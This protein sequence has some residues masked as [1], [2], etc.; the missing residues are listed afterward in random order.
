MPEAAFPRSHQPPLAQE[1]SP[2]RWLNFSA[3]GVLTL[4]PGKVEIGQGILTAYAQVAVDELGVSP[5]CLRLAPVRTGQSPNEGVTS[6]SQSVRESVQRLRAHCATIRER[7]RTEIARCLGVAAGDLQLDSGA[8]LA[9]DGRSLSYWD[10]P[11]EL[12]LEKPADDVAYPPATR[13]QALPRIDL[14]ARI[15]GERRYLHDLT[16]PGM[17][18]GRMLRDAAIGTHPDLPEPEAFRTAFP[19]VLLVQEGGMIG[20]VAPSEHRLDQACRALH[21]RLVWHGGTLLPDESRLADWL[22]SARAETSLV[23]ASGPGRCTRQIEQ[24]Y[25]RPFLAHA[26]IGPSCAIARWQDGHLHVLSHSQGP[27]NLR[28][29]LAL[30]FGLSPEAVLVEHSEGAGCYGHNGA[31]DV[32]LDAALLSRAVNGRPVRVQ[33]SRRDELAKAPFGAAMR[34]RMAAD[35]DADGRITAWEHEI[36]SNGHTARP[37]RAPSPVLLA[38]FERTGEAPHAIAVDPTLAGGGG[39]AERNAVPIYDLPDMRILK[40]RIL[41]QPIRTSSLRSLGAHGN[42]FA[43]ESFMDELAAASGQDPLAFR[44]RHL[45][46]ERAHAVLERVAAMAGW[47]RTPQREGIGRG[48]AFARY[49]NSAGY[50]AAIVDLELEHTPRARHLWLAA[51]VGEAISRDGVLNQIEGGAIQSLSWSLLEQVRFDRERITSTSWDSYPILR[52]DAVP[53]IEIALIERPGLAPLGAGEIAQGPV[54]AAL[55]NAVANGLGAR[56]R[57]LPI[58]RETILSSLESA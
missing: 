4:T 29:D 58:T 49:K 50:L 39:G 43:I 10:I 34:I 20:L 31:D 17:H 48:L 8:F 32:A 6:G 35:L 42:I 2:A 16:L 5:A 54:A 7:A 37:G 13:R 45:T 27:Y 33:W 21:A 51:D 26:A 25:E 38:H 1:N 28:A 30:A 14:A 47:H 36:W 46:D 22:L 41:D 53:T 11:P 57:R 12:M 52:F 3:D 56:V 40:N 19:D 24:V 23:A 9:P 15:L 18:Y 44:L 55:A